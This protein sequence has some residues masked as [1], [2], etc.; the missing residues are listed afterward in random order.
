MQT[1]FISYVRPYYRKDIGE[2]F[3]TYHLITKIFNNYRRANLEFKRICKLSNEAI[4]F[5]YNDYPDYN[6]ADIAYK[7][8]TIK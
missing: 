2:T 7:A 5:S 1:Y 3:N 4:L 6:V 8:R